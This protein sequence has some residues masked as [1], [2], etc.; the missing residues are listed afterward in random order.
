MR[1]LIQLREAGP[2]DPSTFY[3]TPSV[4]RSSLS[5][6]R[7]TQKRDLVNTIVS[8]TGPLITWSLVNQLPLLKRVYPVIL[9]PGAV[10]EELRD[11]RHLSRPGH[12]L[13]ER[14]WIQRYELDLPDDSTLPRRFGH[15]EKEAIRLSRHA[16]LVLLIDDREARKAAQSRG[17]NTTATLETLGLC[18]KLGLLPFVRPLLEEMVA[19]GFWISDARKD[20]FLEQMGEPDAMT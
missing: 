7:E 11:Q 16:D 8:D 19:K 2:G 4:L 3:W 17:I 9:V 5:S 12:D 6:F 13:L 15:G 1:T 18:K 10:V 20:R 14:G